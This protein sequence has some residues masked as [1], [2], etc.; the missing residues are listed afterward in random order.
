MHVFFVLSK[1]DHHVECCHIKLWANNV[2]NSRHLYP[3]HRELQM[4]SCQLNEMCLE[5]QDT[6]L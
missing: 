6:V 3:A 1:A 5:T 2:N 4:E